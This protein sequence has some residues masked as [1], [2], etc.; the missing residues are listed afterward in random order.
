MNN[1]GFTMMEVLAA[2]VIVSVILM[3]VYPSVSEISKKNNEDKYHNY[4]K[5]MVEYAM[6]NKNRDKDVLKLS[7]L[8]DLE[9]IINPD[10][11]DKK[12]KGYV[13]INHSTNPNTF[14]AFISCDNGTYIT[15]GYN[16][17]LE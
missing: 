11:T 2:I 16:T 3:V 13:T 6:I 7:E 12:C 8:D 15:T 17:S 4:E 10:A 14:N 5:M 1:K 9:L